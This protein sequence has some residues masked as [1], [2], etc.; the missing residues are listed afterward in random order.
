V[1]VDTAGGIV[2]AGAPAQGSGFWVARL[3]AS[4]AAD[5]TFGSGGSVTVGSGT[6]E[7]MAVQSDGRI[8]LAGRGT[9]GQV[10][11][12]RL[13]TGGG[14]DPTFGVMGVVTL[15]QP[16]ITSI[17]GLA[18]DATGIVLTGSSGPGNFAVVR[19]WQ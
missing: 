15:L 8:I 14:A 7:L 19:V 1:A 11:I 18:L 4:G 12:R 5:P 17:N 10:E 13:L 3:N 9:L 16:F 6:L 2:V